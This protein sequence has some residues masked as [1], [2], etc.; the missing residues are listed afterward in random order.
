MRHK[1]KHHRR[2]SHRRSVGAVNVKSLATKVLSVA[3]GAFVGRTIQNMAAKSLPTTSPKIVALG[4]ILIGGFVPRFIKSDFG[5]GLGNGILAVGAI[6]GLQSFGV[7]SGI[8]WVP[9]VPASAM[10]YSSKANAFGGYNPKA[11]AF[12]AS[13]PYIRDSVGEMPTAERELMMGALMYE[14]D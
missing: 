13:R 6:S 4:T 2:R 11:R 9:S 10:G 7:I 8:G 1:K 12:G 3:A 5:Q 14:G